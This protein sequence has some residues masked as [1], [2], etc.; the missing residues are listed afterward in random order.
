[1]DKFIE[2]LAYLFLDWQQIVN[3]NLSNSLF[4]GALAFF[5]GMLLTVVLVKSVVSGLKQQLIKEKKNLELAENKRA[6]LVKIQIHDAEQMAEQ[7][8]KHNKTVIKL[9]VA[10]AECSNLNIKQQEFSKS[11]LAKTAEYDDLGLALD[12]K[13]QLLVKLQ[14]EFD[15]Q[16]NK[17]S[18]SVV[19]K[20]KLDELEKN[21]EKTD[22]Q[23]SQVKQQILQLEGELKDKNQLIEGLDSSDQAAKINKDKV[24]ALQAQI[25]QLKNDNT[26]QSKQD[27]DVSKTDYALELENTVKQHDQQLIEFNKKLQLLIT[28]TIPGQ[29]ISSLISE[30]KEDDGFVGKVLNMF[31]SIDKATTG[32]SDLDGED[33]LSINNEDIWQKHHDIIEQLTHQL[34]AEENTK[35]MLIVGE[36]SQPVASNSVSEVAEKISENSAELNNE[37]SESLDSIQHKLKGI[38]NK[39]IS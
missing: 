34:I 24:T 31:A 33:K 6:E 38:Y 32:E 27:K 29:Q 20:L 11:L 9:Q 26:N 15:E 3:E 21:A 13:S 28:S 10:E 12:E 37:K 16:K 1:M 25:S 36:Q 14:S 39:I 17:L 35:E 19:D 4:L 18:Q 8:Q 22:Q 7:Q 5:V 23:A 30:N 2:I